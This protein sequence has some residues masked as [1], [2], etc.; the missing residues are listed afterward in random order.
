MIEVKLEQPWNACAPIEV[1]EAGR[2]IEVKLEQLENASSPIEV[3]ESGRVI[4]VK[5]EEVKSNTNNELNCN[6]FDKYFAPS[7]PILLSEL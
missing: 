1:R 6:E 4:E 2:V 3:T 7:S 5:L